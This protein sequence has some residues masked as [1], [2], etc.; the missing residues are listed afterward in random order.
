MSGGTMNSVLMEQA[1]L[2][3]G[4]VDTGSL[5]TLLECPVCLD[6]ITPPIKQCVK[7]DM[8]AMCDCSEWRVDN[9]D[10]KLR[11]GLHTSK[12]PL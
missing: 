1:N 10:I 12:D 9:V 5:L 2:E 7:A 3:L 4:L 8:Q 6:H 11:E